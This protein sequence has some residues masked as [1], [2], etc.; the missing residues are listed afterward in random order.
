MEA[1]NGI[2]LLPQAPK[3]SRRGR[4]WGLSSLQ[5]VR[6]RLA[7]VLSDIDSGPVD[8]A[9][10]ARA[11]VLIYGLSIAAQILKDEAGGG[12]ESRIDE[13]YRIVIAKE[14]GKQ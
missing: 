9:E 12:L 6:L 7:R 10:L 5:A 3:A 2:F 13:L 1:E 8:A 11:R 4:G 14:G